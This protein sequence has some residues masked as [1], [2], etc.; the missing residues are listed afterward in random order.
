MRDNEVTAL[1]QY[2]GRL[3]GSEQGLFLGSSAPLGEASNFVDRYL[4]GRVL[5]D[6]EHF[7][8]LIEN[9]GPGGMY[10]EIARTMVFGKAS[11]QVHRRL[12]D[13]TGGAESQPLENQ[14]GRARPRR[15]GRA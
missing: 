5:K 12:R 10:T 14:A 8:L 15:R 13:G 2:E 3:L 6:G 9:A 4:Q 11:N 7:S 1:A